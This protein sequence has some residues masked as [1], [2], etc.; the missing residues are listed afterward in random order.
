M[1]N[2]EKLNPNTGFQIQ[3][4]RKFVQFGFLALTL[5]IGIEFIL[6]VHQLENELPVTTTRPAGAEAFLPISALISLKYW[7]LTGIINTIHPSALI[8]L[9]IICATAII[10]KKGS[11]VGSVPSDCYPST[12]KKF[13]LL[14]LLNQSVYRAGWIIPCGV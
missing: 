12:L 7:I 3:P 5:W 8:L 2:L 9:L 10:L 14:F 13:I 4:Y 1:I 11:A 6:F